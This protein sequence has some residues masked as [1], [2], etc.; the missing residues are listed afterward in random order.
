MENISSFANIFIDKGHVEPIRFYVKSGEFSG[1][2]FDLQ[3]KPELSNLDDPVRQQHSLSV[4]V[5]PPINV[6]Y[7]LATKDYSV[8]EGGKNVFNYKLIDVDSNEKLYNPYISWHGSGEVHANAYEL[9]NGEFKT[10][11][12]VKKKD[13][14]S[15]RDVK[16]A[17]NLIIRAIIPVKTSALEKHVLDPSETLDF[18]KPNIPESAIRNI[19]FDSTK[20]V[21]EVVVVDIFVHNRAYEFHHLDQLPYPNG[22]EIMWLA[23]PIKFE[24]NASV[25]LPAVT[26][27]AYQPVG[28]DGEDTNQSS[29]ILEGI[30]LKHPYEEIYISAKR[31]DSITT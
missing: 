18:I 16:M 2:L 7:Q 17:Y 23:P 12:I 8:E 21:R 14:V 25:F 9:V 15:W 11:Q 20:L 4:Y 22:G 6:H 24:N 26:I 3:M 31:V 1:V 13:A 5:K 28:V 10:K 30:T 29:L 19:V 27:F